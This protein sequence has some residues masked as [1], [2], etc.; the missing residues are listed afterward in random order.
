MN[1]KFQ[2]L[3][4]SKYLWEEPRMEQ[5]FRYFIETEPGGMTE[6]EARDRVWDLFARDIVKRTIEGFGSVTGASE[7][8]VPE[9]T[10][11][12]PDAKATDPAPRPRVPPPPPY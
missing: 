5:T 7:K 11:P 2:E 9:N 1:I 10:L 4:E 3:R 8:K 12:A 6:E